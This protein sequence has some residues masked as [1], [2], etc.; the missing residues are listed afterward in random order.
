MS[1]DT[2]QQQVAVVYLSDYKRTEVKV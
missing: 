1:L 2:N